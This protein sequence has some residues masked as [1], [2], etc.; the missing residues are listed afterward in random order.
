MDVWGRMPLP[1]IPTR[2]Q[3]PREAQEKA[4]RDRSRVKSSFRGRPTDIVRLQPTPL[5]LL[6]PLLRARVFSRWGGCVAVRSGPVRYR[7]ADPFA[8]SNLFSGEGCMG[9]LLEHDHNNFEIAP[10]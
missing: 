3:E 7:K 10:I 2:P 9:K 5:A 4:H 1:P 8:T 6:Q